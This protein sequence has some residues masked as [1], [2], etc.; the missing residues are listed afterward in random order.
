MG[1]FCLMYR[2]K[3]ILFFLLCVIMCWLFY[4]I[5]YFLLGKCFVFIFFC[6]YMFIG[7]FFVICGLDYSVMECVCGCWDV[8]IC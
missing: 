8:F 1:F 5:F 3:Y 7:I 6:V 2:C 4:Y